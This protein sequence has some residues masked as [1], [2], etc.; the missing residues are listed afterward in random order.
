VDSK[1]KSYEIIKCPDEKCITE[2]NESGEFYLKLA[3]EKKEKY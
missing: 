1:I 3:K 2:I